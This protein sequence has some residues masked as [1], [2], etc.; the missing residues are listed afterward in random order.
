M[1]KNYMKPWLQKV[2]IEATLMNQLS[3]DIGID[4]GGNASDY[5]GENGGNLPPLDAKPFDDEEW[6]DEY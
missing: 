2:E 5:E 1:K 4:G 3:S 6:D